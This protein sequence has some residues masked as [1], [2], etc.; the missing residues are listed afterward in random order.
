[1]AYSAGKRLQPAETGEA[2]AGRE[3]V[4]V[5]ALISVIHQAPARGQAPADM[6]VRPVPPG[7][8]R[9]CGSFPGLAFWAILCPP[10][11]ADSAY[12][13]TGRSISQ[14]PGMMAVLISP[15]RFSMWRSTF[16]KLESGASPVM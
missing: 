7:L 13:A 5:A 6:I 4:P 12:F 14:W 11:G 9:S 8:V 15:P 1:M 16:C 3:S 2:G 10:Y